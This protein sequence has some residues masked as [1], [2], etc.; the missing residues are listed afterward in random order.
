MM[1]E[2]GMASEDI[3]YASTGGAAAWMGGKRVR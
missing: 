3:L 2:A 1:Q